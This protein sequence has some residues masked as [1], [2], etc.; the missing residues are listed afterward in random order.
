MA[1]TLED[2]TKR[3]HRIREMSTE[4]QLLQTPD[5]WV[6]PAQ[7]PVKW[8]ILQ[9]ITVPFKP[10]WLMPSTA[11][12]SWPYWVLFEFYTHDQNKYVDVLRY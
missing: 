2:L 7:Q 3:P 1:A 5:I 8:G 6:S 4:F 9:M 12:M 10:F 11:E